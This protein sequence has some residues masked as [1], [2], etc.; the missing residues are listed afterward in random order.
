MKSL[1]QAAAL[2]V[3]KPTEKVNPDKSSYTA[4]PEPF[5]AE[6]V[7][8]RAA[9]APVEVPIEPE[10]EPVYKPTQPI[11]EQK[12]T[13]APAQPYKTAGSLE[14]LRRKATRVAAETEV[15]P[16]IKREVKQKLSPEPVVKSELVTKPEPKVEIVETNHRTEKSMLQRIFSNVKGMLADSNDAEYLSSKRVV[17]FLAFICCTIAFFVDLFSNYNVSANLFDAMMWI[18]IAGLGFTG[19]E[20]FAPKK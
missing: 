4:P 10:Q 16:E 18:V 7:I 5:L 11:V 12:T 8:E 19:L 1:R 9:P 15:K 2:P 6:P 13:T 17:A 14:E 20:K 3:I